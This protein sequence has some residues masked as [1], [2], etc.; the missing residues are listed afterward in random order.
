M[1]SFE[2]QL[3]QS[4]IKTRPP[5][6]PEAP[7]APGRR[8]VLSAR[9]FS[10][11]M[12]EPGGRRTRCPGGSAPLGT[13]ACPVRGGCGGRTNGACPP[14][15]RML[16]SGVCALGGGAGGED[17][18]YSVRTAANGEANGET[19]SG[20][21]TL[22]VVVGVVALLAL[23]GG[24]GYYIY[25]RS[26]ND[27]DDG[28]NSGQE[29]ENATGVART[30]ASGLSA[31]AAAD[32]QLGGTLFGSSGRLPAFGFQAR[33]EFGDLSGSETSSTSSEEDEERRELYG[34][35]GGSALYADMRF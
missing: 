8:N 4:L 25:S 1:Q 35:G 30:S 11:T 20:L 29:S 21:K 32:G 18:I 9:S 16:P 17:T 33:G 28:S 22:G 19:S 13:G 27:D 23:I 14:G 34:G 5:T 26:R 31:A 12:S 24:I 7:P 3:L 10:L 6:C 2:E 15:S